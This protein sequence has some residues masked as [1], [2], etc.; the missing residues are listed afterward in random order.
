MECFGGNLQFLVFPKPFLK[1]LFDDF[2]HQ[3]RSSKLRRL[4]IV[5]PCTGTGVVDLNP[6]Y[7]CTVISLF[8]FLKVFYI[9]GSALKLKGSFKGLEKTYFNK[10]FKGNV[11][12]T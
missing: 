3:C 10:Y 5:G 9:E 1:F 7:K 8:N 4:S 12:Q 11:I 2:I 6:N